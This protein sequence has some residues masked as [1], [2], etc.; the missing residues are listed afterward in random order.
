MFN[1]VGSLRMFGS[2]TV[3]ATRISQIHACVNLREFHVN[4]GEL[5]L[6]FGNFV[7]SYESGDSGEIRRQRAR[8]SHEIRTNLP[9]SHEFRTNVLRNSYEIRTNFANSGPKVPEHDAGIFFGHRLG[10]MGPFGV[11]LSLNHGD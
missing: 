2:I 6:K 3:N 4:L 9:N 10:L 8:H 7:N 5:L 11:G 1:L